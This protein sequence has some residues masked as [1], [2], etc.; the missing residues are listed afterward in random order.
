MNASDSILTHWPLTVT[1]SLPTSTRVGGHQATTAVSGDSIP[2]HEAAE[3]LWRVLPP[4]VLLAGTVGDVLTLL[5]MR[6]VG[7]AGAC[8]DQSTAVYLASLAL[9][10][11]AVLWLGL[12]RKWVKSVFRYDV[13]VAHA[14]VCKLHKFLVYTAGRAAA[15]IL[16]AVTTQRVT[17]VMWPLR[18]GLRGTRRKAVSVVVAITA[19]C[20]SV[21]ASHL[22]TYSLVRARSGRLVCGT[23]GGQGLGSLYNRKVYPWV[24]IA[25]GSLLPLGLLLVNNVVLA[26]RV[27]ESLTLT[28]SM[29][30]GAAQAGSR[31]RKASSLSVT[32][33][34]TSVA[35]FLLTSSI[36]VGF[37]FQTFFLPRLP[38]S[39]RL[40]TMVE[41][42]HA[43]L[44]LLWYCNSAVHFYL[45]CLTGARFRNVARRLLCPAK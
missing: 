3:T 16:V 45:Y 14:A 6:A 10:D 22:V 36:P 30:T 41:L 7:P 25:L 32:L 20:A 39:G 44:D 13:R 43:V 21:D 23:L 17:S 27:R 38:S 29:S 31:E 34:I 4:F 24:N 37:F 1:T 12:T 18:Q 5:V 2:Q 11:L 28:R 35:F 42:A 26:W 15:W 8:G 19:A 40:Q 33:I 9:C